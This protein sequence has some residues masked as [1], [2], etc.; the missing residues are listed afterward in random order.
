MSARRL[1]LGVA[2]FAGLSFAAAAQA[3]PLGAYGNT[4][5]FDR[6]TGQQTDSGLTYLAWDQGRSWGSPYSYFLGNLGE[7]PHIALKT[8]KGGG[9]TPQG[10]ARGKGDAHLIGL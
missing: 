2:V 10:I 4:D 1:A 8:A 5:R 7:R 3:I 6:L 9:I